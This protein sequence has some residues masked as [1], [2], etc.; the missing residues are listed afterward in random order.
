M[1]WN[2]KDITVKDLKSSQLTTLLLCIM[3]DT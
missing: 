3:D 1:A 2:C